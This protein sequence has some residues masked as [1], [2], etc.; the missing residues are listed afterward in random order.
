MLVLHNS[1]IKLKGGTSMKE[2]EK[3]TIIHVDMDAFYASVEM[4]DNPSLVGK[5]VA[6]G[7]SSQKDVI[8]TCNYEARKYGVHSSMSTFMAKQ[9]CPNLIIIKPRKEHYKKISNEIMDVFREFSDLVEKVSVDE[10]YLDVTENKVNESDGELIAKMIKKRIFQKIKL[11]SSTGISFNKSLAKLASDMQKPDGLTVI[12]E[13]NVDD[14]LENLLVRKIKGVGAKMEHKMHQR[15]IY[16]GKDLLEKG[17]SYL[18][19][20]FG[21][22]GGK[23]WLFI[24]KLEVKKVIPDKKK[25]SIGC[26][27]T[28]SSNIGDMGQLEI[29]VGKL[30]QKVEKDLVKK[31]CNG[32]T[33]TLKIKYGDFTEK[34]KAITNDYLFSS[35]NVLAKYGVELLKDVIEDGKKVRLLGLRVSKLKMD[36]EVSYQQEEFDFAKVI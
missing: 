12:D 21:A 17:C 20:E 30:A 11:T 26:E 3:R 33:L 6:V 35:E 28:F 13:S 31:G 19:K 34:T 10:V 8:A 5:P 1:I 32:K 25:K 15:N 9:K 7:G 14:I 36:N 23:F 27:E 24:S 16:T 2:E 29:E 4:R 22:A 18:L